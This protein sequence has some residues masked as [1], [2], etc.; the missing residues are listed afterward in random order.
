[1]REREGEITPA[2]GPTECILVLTLQKKWDGRRGEA[3]KFQAEVQG[4]TEKLQKRGRDSQPELMEK[5]LVP[6]RQRALC[7]ICCIP[8]SCSCWNGVKP[9]SQAPVTKESFTD[10]LLFLFC[11]LFLFYSNSV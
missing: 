1:M 2:L 6:L 4:D 9:G 7:R 8:E 10:L 3:K 5:A 11:L